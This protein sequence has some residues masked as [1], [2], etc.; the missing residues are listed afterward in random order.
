MSNAV[1]FTDSGGSVSV[2]AS[3]VCGEEGV[4]IAVSDT[5]I[6]IPRDKQR[7]VFERF[8]QANMSTVRRYGGS[9]LGLFL[10]E[11]LVSMLGGR[12]E[13]ESEPGVGSVFTVV[14]PVDA[15]CARGEGEKGE[16][17]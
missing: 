14:L 3:R 6:G 8:A 17:P 15:A 4:A 16:T 10:V 12:V 7:L 9:G 5:G 13:L 11:S 2:R 1:K